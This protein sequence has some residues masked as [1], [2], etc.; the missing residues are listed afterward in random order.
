MPLFPEY[1]YLDIARSCLFFSYRFCDCPFLRNEA[2]GDCGLRSWIRAMKCRNP[3]VR[4]CLPQWFSSLPDHLLQ[5]LVLQQAKSAPVD[6]FGKTSKEAAG[7]VCTGTHH[8]FRSG[9]LC[10]F[11][12][13]ATAGDYQVRNAMRFVFRK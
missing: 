11:S 7:Q 6:R 3:F 4:V 5:P 8:L 2:I 13:T 1:D 10:S 9:V 12:F